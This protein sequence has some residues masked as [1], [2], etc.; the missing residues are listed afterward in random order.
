MTKSIKNN[1]EIEFINYLRVFAVISILLCHYMPESNNVYLQM[2]AQF[3]NIG[4]NIFIIISGFCLGLQG[5]ITDVKLWYRKRLKRIYIPYWIFLFSLSVVYIIKKIKFNFLNWLSCILGIQGA[6]VGVWGADHTWFITAILICYLV[7]PLISKGFHRKRMIEG[8]AWGGAIIF[9]LIPWPFVF[10]LLSP[11]CFYS[12]AY[13][14]GREYKENSMTFSKAI[15]T[16]VIMLISFIVRVGTKIFVDGTFFY[17]RIIVTYTQY[18]AAFAIFALFAFAFKNIK[19]NRLC[20]KFCEISFEVYLC[21]YMFVV[22][23][24]SLM[25]ITT[26]FVMNM[27]ITTF[28]SCSIAMILHYIAKKTQKCI[29]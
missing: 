3:F 24:I 2:S 12:L 29:G 16:L 8:L 15:V 11:V 21:H 9:S 23:P 19:S 17:D 7:T 14:A 28:V 10:T 1:Q 25:K 20:K 27:I 22:G 26:S 18:I 5:E 4:V 6:N 13:F